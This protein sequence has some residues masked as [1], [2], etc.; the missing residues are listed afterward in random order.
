MNKEKKTFARGLLKYR[1]MN[2]LSQ[3]QMCQKLEVSLP[4]YRQWEQGIV[5]NPKESNL[6]KIQVLLKDK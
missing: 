5:K 6:L 4:T 1:I 3:V 2:D